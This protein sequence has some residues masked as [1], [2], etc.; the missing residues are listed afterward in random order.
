MVFHGVPDGI[1]GEGQASSIQKREVC[2]H[3]LNSHAEPIPVE[4][5]RSLE[6]FD[7]ENDVRDLRESARHV[8]APWIDPADAGIQWRDTGP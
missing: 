6:I 1:Q 4:L 2:A 5:Q 7:P 8:T 3:T